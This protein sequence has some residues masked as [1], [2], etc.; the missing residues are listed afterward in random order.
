LDV[1]LLVPAIQVRCLREVGI[2]PQQDPAEAGTAAELNALVELLGRA[3]VT[4]AIAAAV[5]QPQNLT[6]AASIAVCS[7]SS[8]VASLVLN[9]QIR[10]GKTAEEATEI[11][12]DAFAKAGWEGDLPAVMFQDLAPLDAS[13]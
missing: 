5:N 8:C 6:R 13:R 9:A 2:T 12:K 3:L 11:L 4:G 7:A 10:Q 1:P